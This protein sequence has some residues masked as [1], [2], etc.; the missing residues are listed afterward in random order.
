MSGPGPTF[1][2][3]FWRHHA[4]AWGAAQPAA[5]RQGQRSQRGGR[6]VGFA[7]GRYKNKVACARVTVHRDVDRDV[8]LRRI[9]CAADAGL[10]I[11]PDGVRNRP[12]GGIVPAASMQLSA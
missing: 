7:G 2:A 1:S 12:A 10:V 4:D 5:A 11:N 9:R 6:G 8:A 3:P